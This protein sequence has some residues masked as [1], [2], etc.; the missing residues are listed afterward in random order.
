MLNKGKESPCK[1]VVHGVLSVLKG[2]LDFQFKNWDSLR[3]TRT[4]D[5]P[6]Q[7]AGGGLAACLQSR[8]PTMVLPR[9]LNLFS[10]NTLFGR[11]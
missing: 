4:V 6:A 1:D 10:G 9:L 7:N 8:T 11:N 2:A 3:Q 5:H